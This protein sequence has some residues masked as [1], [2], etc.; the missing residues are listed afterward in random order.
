MSVIQKFA[1]FL[2]ETTFD[3]LPKSTIDSAKSSL[4]DWTG[5]ALAA[6]DLTPSQSFRSFVEE[7][8]GEPQASIFGSRSKTST[9]NAVWVNAAISHILDFDDV[10]VGQP[11]QPLHPSV[12][13]APV[14]F[15]LAE[16]DKLNGR[17]LLAAFCLGIETEA[18][19]SAGLGTTH[20][21]KGFH[22]T[23]T[24][25]AFGAAVAAGKLLGLSTDEL[26]NALC[27]AASGSAGLRSSFGTAAKPVQVAR[28]AVN[29]LTAA[30]LA[31]KG[32]CGDSAMIDGP[33]GFT[34]VFSSAS[35]LEQIINNLGTTYALDTVFYK[36]YASCGETHGA[37]EAVL[38]L[39]DRPILDEIT[40]VLVEV[41]KQS[42]EVANV[43]HPASGLSAKFSIPHCTALAL[44][45]G[46]VDLTHFSDAAVNDTEICELRK[47]V[48]ITAN[49]AERGGARV[50]I[51]TRSGDTVVGTSDRLKF[52]RDFAQRHLKVD[53]KFLALSSPLIGEDRARKYQLRIR[54]LEMENSFGALLQLWNPAE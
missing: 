23:S 39:K 5:V 42:I 52:I 41:P 32:L 4:L 45:F 15:A 38:A 30:L 33:L 51:T 37:I 48:R 9:T 3:D 35:D 26:I 44:M 12:P 11:D 1:G 27:F 14:V 17:Q 24:M 47:K 18:R 8:G 13:I 36:W 25:G 16:R 46:T 21:A 6:M 10:Y 28:A 20:Y 40:D 22:A 49:P 50:K 53:D 7:Q 34:R 29:G 43:M 2:T 31:A 54:E 19:I